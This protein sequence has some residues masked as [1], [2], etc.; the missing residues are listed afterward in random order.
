MKYFKI[1]PIWNQ[2]IPIVFLIVFYIVI[3]QI[4]TFNH[5]VLIVY[6]NL[7]GFAIAWESRSGE[8]Y[9]LQLYVIKF[10]SD[11]QKVGGFLRVLRFPPPIK[12]T[13]KI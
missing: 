7:L 5:C 11:L 1:V 6:T 12:P 8:V 2:W 13:A 4:F 10:V 9:S 3:N